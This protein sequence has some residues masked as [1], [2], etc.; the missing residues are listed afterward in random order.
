MKHGAYQHYVV[1]VGVKK[2]ANEKTL[3]AQDILVIDPYMGAVRKLIDC[4]YLGKKCYSGNDFKKI[5]Y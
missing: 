4:P 3:K 2:T 5:R 1:D